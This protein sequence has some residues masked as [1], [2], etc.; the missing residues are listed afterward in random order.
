M[1][2]FKTFNAVVKE[3]L[4]KYFEKYPEKRNVIIKQLDQKEDVVDMM[5]HAISDIMCSVIGMFFV[6][7]KYNCNLWE[8]D[9]VKKRI[10]R[11][12]N[13]EPSIVSNFLEKVMKEAK[14]DDIPFLVNFQK[15]FL[16]SE[17]EYVLE[18]T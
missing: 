10:L 7:K 2:E 11:P 6:N 15:A 14:V 18:H 17:F 5:P 13:D 12:F 1:S 16:S 8:W 3:W 9:L 4:Y